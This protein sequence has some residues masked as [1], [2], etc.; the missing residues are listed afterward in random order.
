M[1][2]PMDETRPID[3]ATD[4]GTAGAETAANEGTAGADAGAVAADDGAAAVDGTAG[5]A[6]NGRTSWRQVIVISVAGFI[7]WTGFGAILPY[8]PI[9]LQEQA[10]SSLFMIGLIASMLYLG[11]LLFASPMGW[12]SDQIGRKPV[13]IMGITIYAVSTFLFTRTTDPMWFVLFRLLEGVGT[14]AVM[15]AGQAFI[16]DITT[17]STRSKAFGLLT[18]AQFGGLI[19]GPA[20]AP[21][22]Y[23]LGGGGMTGFYMIFYFGAALSAMAAVAAFALLKEPPRRHPRMAEQSR[24]ER[25]IL[26]PRKVLLSPAV[27]AFLLVAFTSHFAMG[28]WEVIWSLYLRELGASMAFIGATWIAF[29]VPMLLAF[30]GGALADR[31]NRFALMFIGYAI[32][33]IAWIYYGVTTNFLLFIIVNVIEGLAIAFSWPAKQAFFVQVVSRRWL[34]TLLGVENSSMQLAGLIGTLSA[35]IIYGWIGGYVLAVGGVVNLVG[36]AIAAPILY[37]VY[38]RVRHEA[39]GGDAVSV[40]CDA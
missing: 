14:A 13:L 11:T 38:E 25:R 1:E 30:F 40:M 5:G 39:P 37:R 17:D 8:L 35:P 15:P 28:A 21:P 33:A 20:L 6:G 4:G 2:S 27:L 31:Y 36:L 24:E 7:V 12:L 3:G 22:L 29:S 16:A 23:H 34:G 10:H 26:P 9:F 18:T 32:S 19:A